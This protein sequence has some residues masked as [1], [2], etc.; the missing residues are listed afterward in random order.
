MSPALVSRTERWLSYI[1]RGPAR[2]F[3]TLNARPGTLPADF[4]GQL[5]D[6]LASLDDETEDW[7]SFETET[8]LELVTK[9]L[10]ATHGRAL[11]P[12]STC[13]GCS[14]PGDDCES[15]RRYKAAVTLVRLMARRGGA[16]VMMPGSC[17]A[18]RDFGHSFHVWFESSLQRRVR[19]FAEREGVSEEQ[20][21]SR[22]EELASR[23]E[24]WLNAAFGPRTEGCG[25]YCH[26]TLNL[27][28]LGEGSLIQIVGDT[29][30]EWVAARE[31]T[32]RHAGRR[33]HE[34][35]G[36]SQPVPSAP[37]GKVIPFPHSSILPD[38]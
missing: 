26:L 31:R 29:V 35:R 5:R 24:D 21:A 33:A 23:Q 32:F 13:R 9:P 17:R 12:A 38:S 27:D 20:A 15:R 2:P 1:S 4:A 34:L 3:V 10:R 11:A 7:Q 25:I 8:L 30:L 28:Q 22:I 19:R 36:E 6:Y 14:C 16:V 37:G 18:T